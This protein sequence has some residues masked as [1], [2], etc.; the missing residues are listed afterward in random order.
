[1]KVG[2]DNVSHT[3]MARERRRGG[4]LRR[5]VLWTAVAG[6]LATGVVGFVLW[7]EL[8]A[9]LP[10]VE[11]LLRYQPPVATR[12]FADDG[13]LIG[14]FYV[15]RRYLVPL[16]RVPQHVRLAFLAAE[17]ADFY[18]HRGINPLSIVRALAANLTHHQVVQGGSTITQQVV[19]TLLLTPERSY[20]RK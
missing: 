18:R 1:M 19:K 11:Q 17:D 16:D 14:E 8:T 15:E 3:S 10:P 20:E 7:R 13:T 4:V 2:A 9:D 6:L 5:L 12:V